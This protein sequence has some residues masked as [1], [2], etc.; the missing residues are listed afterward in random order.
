MK[1]LIMYM[2]VWLLASAA[3]QADEPGRSRTPAS[4]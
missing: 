1:Q 3:M 4:G 2:S